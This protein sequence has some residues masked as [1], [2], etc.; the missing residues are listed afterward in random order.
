MAVIGSAASAG[1]LYFFTYDMPSLDELAIPKRPPAITI[2][3]A[4]GQIMGR[5]GVV[6]AGR[7]GVGELPKHLLQ[8]VIATEDRRFYDHI[9]ID[10]IGLARAF[11][12]NYQAG[13]VVQGGST[14]T[15]QLAK[16]LF[17]KPERRIK[18]KVQ[19]A[20]LALR[21]ESI[22]SKDEIIELY[23]NRI[24]FGAGTYGIEAA[25]ERYFD[26]SAREVTLGEAAILAGLLKAPTRFAPTRNQ[27]RSVKRATIVLNKMA[28][29]GFIT[30]E[31]RFVA[32]AV[33]KT[34]EA[35][36]DEF[37]IAPYILDWVAESLTDVLGEPRGDLVVETTIDLKLQAVAL[38][39][40]RKAIAEEGEA[41]KVSQATVV[42]MDTTGATKALV[43]G[44]DYKKSQFNRA[45]KGLRQPGSTFK[46]LVYLAAMEFGYSPF[47]ERV[48]R[49]VNING[50]EP[51]N[52]SKKYRGVV[53]LTEALGR[54]INTVAAQVG[55]EI[56][57]ESVVEL[58]RRLGITSPL[59]A[60]PSLALGTGE[61]TLF[62]LTG[63]FVPLANGGMGVTPHVIAR[64]YSGEG[65]VLF[66]RYDTQTNRVLQPENV[67]AMNYML[68]GVTSWGTGGR[69]RLK[70]HQ[71]A[72]KT[73]TTQD[74]RDA[75]FIGY[76]NYFIGGV[77]V[78]NDDNSA[79]KR[80]TGGSI[81]A[82]IFKEVMTAAHEGLK[83]VGL[84]IDVAPPAPMEPEPERYVSR[85]PVG[86]LLGAIFGFGQPRR[87]VVRRPIVQPSLTVRSPFEGPPPATGRRLPV[88]EPLP[89]DF[90]YDGRIVSPG[91]RQQFDQGYQPGTEAP[92]RRRGLFDWGGATSRDTE[93]R[94]PRSTTK[95]FNSRRDRDAYLRRQR[96]LRQ[97]QNN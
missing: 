37:E 21:L 12:A 19:E 24:Y 90:G 97:Q 57:I 10:F 68:T 22:Y 33:L 61:V 83:P 30:E 50:W 25:A 47:D 18:R 80:V 85:G 66:Q 78:G 82:K 39:V 73:G 74:Y 29:A 15:Q 69:A 91:N 96:A 67:T 32:E 59:H 34:P 48:D 7:V 45:V 2:M 75:W 65:K 6:H 4:D 3:A 58:S 86:G 70:G 27:D 89:D 77:W 52:Y 94:R 54:S 49:P 79:M 62:E 9:G 76:T 93:T 38:E 43:G 31:E 17:L 42:I 64:V 84:P 46:A 28:E 56:G 14:L 26:K 44:L 53:T 36:T 13:H 71:T 23:L 63:A 51:G 35:K 16:N 95:V 40:A 1:I 11:Y 81:P 87:A 60:N 8:A 55:N 41:K 20:V 72:G 92:R 5:R 88:G